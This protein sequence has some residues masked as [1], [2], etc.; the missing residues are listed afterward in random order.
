MP[1]PIKLGK[2]SGGLG[3]TIGLVDQKTERAFTGLSGTVVVHNLERD[4]DPGYGLNGD[5]AHYT[6][7]LEG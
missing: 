3:S 7:N 5:I 1:F 6:V 4:K 2:Q